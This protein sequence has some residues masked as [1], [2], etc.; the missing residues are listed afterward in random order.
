MSEETDKGKLQ[1]LEILEEIRGACDDPETLG[2][3]GR[4]IQARRDEVE[5]VLR[6]GTPTRQIIRD[7][8]TNNF[9]LEEQLAIVELCEHTGVSFHESEKE[10]NVGTTLNA[11]RNRVKMATTVTEKVVRI[12]GVGGKKKKGRSPKKVVK[13]AVRNEPVHVREEDPELFQALVG[14]PYFQPDEIDRIKEGSHKIF[15]NSLDGTATDVAKLQEIADAIKLETREAMNFFEAVGAYCFQKKRFNIIAH[16]CDLMRKNK[17]TSTHESFVVMHF[18]HKANENNKNAL[19]LARDFRNIFNPADFI[20]LASLGIKPYD[21]SNNTLSFKNESLDILR[22]LLYIASE[23]RSLT[24]SY[25]QNTLETEFP[26]DEKR[27]G[28]ML[29]E[30]S[31]KGWFLK[32]TSCYFSNHSEGESHEPSQLVQFIAD[33]L[34]YYGAFQEEGSDPE[35]WV[36]QINP[37]IIMNRLH[38]LGVV[39][40][41]T[42]EEFTNLYWTP[43]IEQRQ[44]SRQ[45]FNEMEQ[46]W[47]ENIEGIERRFHVVCQGLKERPRRGIKPNGKDWIRINLPF[48]ND[49]IT[50]VH[51]LESEDMNGSDAPKFDVIFSINFFGKQIRLRSNIIFDENGNRFIT[52]TPMINAQN[53]R[54]SDCEVEGMINFIVIN[55]LWNL[56][57]WHEKTPGSGPDQTQV[58]QQTDQ[59]SQNVPRTRVEVGWYFRRLPEGHEPSQDSLE[60]AER[61]KVNIPQGHT[62]VQGYD[63][64]RGP[65]SLRPIDRSL[66]EQIDQVIDSSRPSMTIGFDEIEKQV[67]P[68]RQLSN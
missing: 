39:T 47:E 10:Q 53:M 54:D 40:R 15:F 21:K 66:D 44:A 60:F 20:E 56:I 51:F 45:A 42:P 50:S 1:D 28:K 19:Q 23:M 65:S 7:R 32:L 62:V 52:R 63:Y 43:R 18:F 22:I 37:A 8:D 41:A 55:S 5:I 4:L 34:I 46:W 27:K 57:E 12:K 3:V 17:Q 48:I 58:R 26:N 2:I 38:S 14:G 35:K 64:E 61:M 13:N 68:Y 9:S 24:T 25:Q 29:L 6:K 36:T 16:C 33:L 30:F 59:S 49:L 11:I 31:G 67:A